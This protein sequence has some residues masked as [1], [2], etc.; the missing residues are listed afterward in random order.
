[1]NPR[2]ATTQ[3]QA[4]VC[5]AMSVAALATLSYFMVVVD[6]AQER[7]EAMRAHQRLTGHFVQ[8]GSS[9]SASSRTEQQVQRNAQSQSGNNLVFAAR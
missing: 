8:L 5:I 4:L 9:A 7:G 6:E 3:P 2:A 1:M